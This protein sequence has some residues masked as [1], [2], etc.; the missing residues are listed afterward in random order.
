ME[1]WKKNIEAVLGDD[2]ERCRANALRYL[3]HLKTVLTF[4]I[5][6]TGRGDFPWEERYVLGGWS[7][8]EYA[9]LKKTNPSYT[10]TFDLI[11]IQ[12]PASDDD[13]LV[14]EIVRKSDKKKFSFG[15][16]WL[17]T[18]TEDNPAFR[19]LDDYATWHVN[20]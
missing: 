9:K 18:D 15:L 14:A 4:P 12:P 13:D 7:K 3:T 11:D 19:E 6:T 20:Y 2:T 17:T 8:V 5:T 10:D 1:D 16:Y